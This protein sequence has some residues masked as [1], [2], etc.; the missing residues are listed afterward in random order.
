PWGRLVRRRT[1]NS[2]SHERTKLFQASMKIITGKDLNRHI[3]INTTGTNIAILRL[4][5]QP[6]LTDYIQPICLDNGRTFGL[7]NYTHPTLQLF[8]CRKCLESCMIF[9]P[10]LTCA[11]LCVGLSRGIPIKF[12]HVCGCNVTKC[13][14]VQGGRILL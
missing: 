13:G 5:A 14:K 12:I 11:P 1:A 7:N 2:L 8:I 6:T 10:L 9:V 3:Y 4:S